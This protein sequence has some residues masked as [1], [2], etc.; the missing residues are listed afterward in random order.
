MSTNCLKGS[1]SDGAMRIN[2]YLARCG[3]GS[4]RKVESL[5][6]RGRVCVNGEKVTSPALKVLPGD[7]VT[8]DGSVV[9][10]A[11]L[12]YAVMHKPRGIVCAASDRWNKTVLDLLPVDIKALRPFPVGRLD[13]ESEGLLILTNDGDFA[14][15]IAH[16][17]FGIL[18]EYETLLDRP[19]ER[20]DMLRWISGL[21]VDGSVRRPMRLVLIDRDPEGQWVSVTLGEGLNREVRKMVEVLGYSVLRLIRRRIGRLTLENIAPG[22]TAMKSRDSLW[23]MIADGGSV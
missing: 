4:R 12:V 2:R 17:R 14:F 7:V 18:K 15:R 6:F 1:S 8:V 13:K 11:G 16:P 3:L 21:W 19:L 22:E 23:R 5:L 9:R 20:E 10:P